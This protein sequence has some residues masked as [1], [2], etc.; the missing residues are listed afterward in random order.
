MTDIDTEFERFLWRLVLIS[1]VAM[2]ALLLAA[3]FV[4]RSVARP[5]RS[6]SEVT[7][8][9]SQGQFDIAIPADDRADEIGALAQSVARLRDEAREA[10]RLRRDQ[11]RAKAQ[12]E[13]ERR[14]ALL[15]MADNFEGSVRSVAEAIVQ[16]ARQTDGAV[17]TMK[18]VTLEA[19]NDAT[20]GA[21]AAHQVNA[22]VQQ[23][24]ASAQQ[25]SYSIHDISSQ[26]RQSAQVAERAVGKATETD[27]LV[28]G[29]TDAVERINEVVQLINDIAAQTNLLALNATIEAARAGEAG[30]GFAVVANE[31]K[32]L[33]SQTAKATGDI[34]SQIEAVKS[35]TGDAVQAIR[36]ITGII[37]QM[38]GTTASIAHAVDEQSAATQLISQNVSQAATGV[39]QLADFLNRMVE[40]TGRVE[41]DAETVSHSSEGLSGRSGDLS[42][43]VDSFL[44]TVRR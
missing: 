1:S 17:R 22:N 21:S 14:S 11:E 15:S 20:S 10:E 25:L 7:E 5:L 30:K 33:A 34:S 18:G 37:E 43:A 27:Q 9:I 23:V 40:I 8:K 42:R 41:Q 4:A 26:V 38:N 12:A 28:L 6:L 3:W 36:E 31:V 16:A 32:H 2:S 24:A 29:L 35:A 13:Q 19:R 39:T 44:A